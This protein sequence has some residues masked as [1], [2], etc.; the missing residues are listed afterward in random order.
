[1]SVWN[2]Q[3][4]MVC[5]AKMFPTFSIRSIRKAGRARNKP[6]MAN[7]DIS[8]D[9]IKKDHYKSGILKKQIRHCNPNM[10]FSLPSYTCYT[11]FAEVFLKYFLFHPFLNH[12]QFCF[13]TL[14]WKAFERFT[15]IL[16]IV[17]VKLLDVFYIFFTDWH[18]CL[19]TFHIGQEC[20]LL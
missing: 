20:P 17:S 7:L 10:F 15:F 18:I 2:Q 19:L 3:I 8:A 5:P 6:I 11:E 14:K 13:M 1:M 16:K 12:C 9:L 4:N